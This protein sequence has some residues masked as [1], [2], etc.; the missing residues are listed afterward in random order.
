MVL[1]LPASEE[2]LSSSL[3]HSLIM[4][5]YRMGGG[6]RNLYFRMVPGDWGPSCLNTVV[7]EALC[8]MAWVSGYLTDKNGDGARDPWSS[9][10]SVPRGGG[11]GPI[12]DVSLRFGTKKTRRVKQWRHQEKKLSG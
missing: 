10:L 3:G 6:L 7:A 5:I 9:A 11:I 2:Q 12:L 4:Y 8:C 1:E